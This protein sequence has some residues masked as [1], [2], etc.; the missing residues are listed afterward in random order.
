L[1]FSFHCKARVSGYTVTYT[2]QNWQGDCAENTSPLSWRL[3]R[4]TAIHP[5]QDGAVRVNT[6]RTS[7]GTE[8]TRPSV[9][10][11]PLLD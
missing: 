4:L 9:K 3:V 11:R 1:S 10:I 7:S 6:L 8:L 5:G 2:D